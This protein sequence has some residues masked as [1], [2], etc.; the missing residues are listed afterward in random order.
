[1]RIYKLLTKIVLFLPILLLLTKETHAVLYD[2]EMINNTK[3]RYTTGQ[4][5]VEV[6]T[7]F[8]RQVQNREYFFSTKGEKIFHIPDSSSGK[9]YEIELERQ[10]KRESISV[11]NNLGKKVAYTVEELELGQGMYIKVPNYKETVYGSPYKVTLSYRTHIYVR[12]VKDWVAIQVPALHE[13]TQF[14]QVDETSD[15]NT[16]IEY[17]LDVIVDNNIPTLSKIFPSQYTKSTDSTNTIYSFNGE[18]RIES[19][20]YIEFGTKRIYRFE[21]KLKTPKTDNIVPE[22]YSSAINALSTNIYQIPLPREFA[23]TNQK[24][25]IE[26]I[27]PKPKKIT[28]DL[29]GNIIGTFEV[30]ANKD[31]AIYIYGYIWVEQN[32]YE[33]IRDIPNYK[34]TEYRELVKKDSKLTQYL[35]P[36]KFWETTD[37]FIQTKALELSTD[38]EYITDVI[39]KDYA[40]INDV[41]EYDYSKADS[42]NERI[43]AKAA[44]QGG[45]S[46]CMEYS[47]SMIALLRAQGI[48]ARAAVGYINLG[49]IKDSEGNVPHQ[50]VQVWVPEYGWLSIDP[51]YESVNMQIGTN[52][53]SILWETFYD[54]DET[55][56]G[57]YTADKIDLSSFTKDNY[58]ISVYAI[59]EQEIPEIDS[60]F[61]YSDIA[62][63]QDGGMEDTLNILVKTTSLGKALIIV[64][65]IT[66]VLILLILLLSL[67]TIL[68]R[69]IKSRKVYQNQ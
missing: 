50:W 58:V 46:V 11:V 28:M 39:E 10:Y 61:S 6:D 56:L 45:S 32:D 22:K 44:L 68:V 9:D 53:D 1:M 30:P 49:G 29:E 15:T 17:N 52:I 43:G 26:E 66:V 62:I 13:D 63:G 65:P 24:V 16:R 5:Y 48:P 21:T 12:A 59:N 64:L 25:M 2:F 18:D 37:T 23:E 38:Q 3:I 60:L 8:I 67:I 40:Y 27:Y 4:D 54:D 36:T 41:L 19:P 34:Y 57:I 14:T 69:R 31:S 42:D 20:V 47:D 35:L 7:E 33:N 51:T 55:N